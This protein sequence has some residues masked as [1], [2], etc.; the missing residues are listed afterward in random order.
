[1]NYLFVKSIH[2]IGVVSWFAGLFYLVRLFVYYVETFDKEQIEQKVLQ[3]QYQVM[4]QRLYY[5]IT[6]PAMGLTLIAGGL[7]LYLQP[8][9]LMAGWMQAKLGL[10]VILLI[11]HFYC[12]WVIGIF[13]RGEELGQSFSFRLLNEVATLLLV[14]IVFL[15]VMKDTFKIIYGILG[16]LSL[17]IFLFLA[18]F[19][20]KKY[21][22][23]KIKK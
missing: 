22:E 13:Q 4:M 14:A 8:H 2:I 21:R 23:K 12:G 18:A 7:M 20:Y 15:V 3:P 5:I 19:G 11:Y 1:M 9:W 6:M 10:V 17:A 16:F